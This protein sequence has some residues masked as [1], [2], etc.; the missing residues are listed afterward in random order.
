MWKGRRRKGREEKEAER[1]GDRTI[2]HGGI[3][4]VQELMSDLPAPFG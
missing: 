2:A 3:R 1:V 4:D